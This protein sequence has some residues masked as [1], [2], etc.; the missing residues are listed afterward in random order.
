MPV[1]DSHCDSEY[2]ADNQGRGHKDCDD[3]RSLDRLVHQQ[4][5][6]DHVKNADQQV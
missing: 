4:E 6:A 5:P 2:A 1:L 3:D